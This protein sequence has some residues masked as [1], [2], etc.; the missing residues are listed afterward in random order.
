MPISFIRFY[1]YRKINSI[2]FKWHHSSFIN[3][4]NRFNRSCWKAPFKKVI[5]TV[6]LGIK[7]G[8]QVTLS[9]LRN[10]TEHYFL[11]VY[12]ACMFTMHKIQEFSNFQPTWQAPRPFYEDLPLRKIEDNLKPKSKPFVSIPSGPV[13]VPKHQTAFW[14]FFREEVPNYFWPFGANP[15]R[16]QRPWKKTVEK[17]TFHVQAVKRGSCDPKDVVVYSWSTLLDIQNP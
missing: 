2:L 13:T 11:T 5:N 8:I 3:H 1:T 16:Q 17:I 15:R 7:I 4:R 9:L 14:F 6:H 10:I 12:H